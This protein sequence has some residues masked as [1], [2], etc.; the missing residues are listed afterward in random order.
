MVQEI[1]DEDLVDDYV[2]EG[3]VWLSLS[4]FVHLLLFV[5]YSIWVFVCLY[6][7]S[8]ETIFS[9]LILLSFRIFY[10][11]QL[12]FNSCILTMFWLAGEL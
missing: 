6:F 4:S 5:V 3:C 10:L 7:T 2:N 12:L 1:F 11:M 9:L 8:V